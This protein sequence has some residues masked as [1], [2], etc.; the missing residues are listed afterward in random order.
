M[1]IKH[2]LR[3]PQS[4]SPTAAV[5]FGANDFNVTK[6]ERLY[7]K[8]GFKEVWKESYYEKSIA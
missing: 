2:I 5:M 6:A 4:S 8:L 1:D 7:E 3:G